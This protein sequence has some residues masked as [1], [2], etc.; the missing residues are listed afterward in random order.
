MIAML[1]VMSSMD[2]SHDSLGYGWDGSGWVYHGLVGMQQV[3]SLCAWFLVWVQVGC[4]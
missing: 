1:T 3:R 2:L 4:M